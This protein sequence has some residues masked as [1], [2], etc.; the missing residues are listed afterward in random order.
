LPDSNSNI[1]TTVY[2]QITYVNL[3]NLDGSN[4]TGKTLTIQNCGGDGHPV[5][6]NASNSW[7][8]TLL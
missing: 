3:K 2:K 1:G 7:R 5:I 4:P 8:W 6:L